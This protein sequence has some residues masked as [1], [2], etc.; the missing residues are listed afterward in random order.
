MKTITTKYII[1]APAEKVWRSLV[2]PKLIDDWGAGPAEM[3]DQEGFEFKL[4][5]G[6]IYGKNIQVVSEQLL[7]QEWTT[8][9]WDNPSKVSFNL[10]EDSG[11]TIVDLLHE[12][13]PDE[14]FEEIKNGWD[15]NYMGP[16]KEYVEKIL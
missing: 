16:L 6:D 10:K 2:D 13:I 4:W 8:S 14:E 15:Q 1:Q 12:D 3:S 5:N 9:S 11:K 7:I